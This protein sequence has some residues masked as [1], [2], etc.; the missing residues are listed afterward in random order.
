[1]LI[2]LHKQIKCNNLYKSNSVVKKFG[3]I[4][5]DCYFFEHHHKHLIKIQYYYICIMQKFLHVHQKMKKY[6]CDQ[7][8]NL[9][10]LYL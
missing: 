1:M 6:S 10:L 8:L 7:L 9:I 5:V 3:N 4:K 2:N